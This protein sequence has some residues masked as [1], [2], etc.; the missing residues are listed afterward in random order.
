[1]LLW[2][3]K[4]YSVFLVL[5]FVPNQSF[6]PTM[7]TN[8]SFIVILLFLFVYDVFL[9]L[10]PSMGDNASRD[11]VTL[12]EMTVRQKVVGPTRFYIKESV[13]LPSSPSPM[14]TPVN[15][16]IDTFFNVND[17]RKD[18]VITTI[19]TV[20]DETR[21]SGIDNFTTHSSISVSIIR[22]RSIK[23]RTHGGNDSSLS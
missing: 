6:L 1:M 2:L 8:C 14:I 16:T 15:A 5:H 11:S 23:G 10:S 4:A 18:Y 12:V 19:T 7:C 22:S 20:K 21:P 9:Y 3:L 17:G 13:E